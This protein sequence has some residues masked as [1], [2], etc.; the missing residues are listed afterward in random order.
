VG[1]FARQVW[2]D[3]ASRAGGRRRSRFQI[4]SRPKITWALHHESDGI[5]RFIRALSGM[6]DGPFPEFYEPSKPACES[7]ASETV[8][9]SGREK[10][11]TDMDKYAKTVTRSFN[12]I[13]TTYRLTEHYHY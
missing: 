1:S 6:Q 8:Q 5:G 12:I 9:Q 4:D 10:Y 7:V 2:W 11:K 13:C 3:D